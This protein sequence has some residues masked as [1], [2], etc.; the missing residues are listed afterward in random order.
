MTFNTFTTHTDLFMMTPTQTGGRHKM[1]AFTV[2]FSRP[3]CCRFFLFLFFSF[4]FFFLKRRFLTNRRRNW[5]TNCHQSICYATPVDRAPLKSEEVCSLGS[6]KCKAAR[7]TLLPA[8]NG[9]KKTPDSY[10]PYISSPKVKGLRCSSK[11]SGAA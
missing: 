6:M 2:L 7:Y 10:W 1:T 4:F 5:V 8:L 9:W 11:S 3:F